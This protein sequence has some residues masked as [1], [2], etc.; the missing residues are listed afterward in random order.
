M[1]NDMGVNLEAVRFNEF[2]NAPHLRSLKRDRNGDAVLTLKGGTKYKV[3]VVDGDRRLSLQNIKEIVEKINQILIEKQILDPNQEAPANNQQLNGLRIN[4]HGVTWNGNV[5]EHTNTDN[6]RGNTKQLY[7]DL[8][9]KAVALN[10]PNNPVQPNQPNQP[11]PPVNPQQP[12]NPNVP[13]QQAPA[14]PAPGAPGAQPLELG[15][16]PAIN[17][18][19]EAGVREITVQADAACRA[20][21]M[22][23]N[24]AGNLQYVAQDRRTLIN[25]EDYA[26][27]LTGGLVVQNIMGALHAI[28]E[29]QRDAVQAAVTARCEDFA[30]N[31]I[32]EGLNNVVDAKI[33]EKRAP[34]TA[35]NK[36]ERD[37]L[38]MTAATEVQQAFSQT[39]LRVGNAGLREKV[40]I[41]ITPEYTL[42]CAN[43]RLR[44]IEAAEAQRRNQP[45]MF[46][47]AAGG[48]GGGVAKAASGLGHLGWGALRRLTGLND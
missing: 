44:L 17:G 1:N 25:W 10:P 21:R 38:V 30:L 9:A 16:I 48:L 19:E 5:F 20:A 28:P 29:N 2:A 18:V 45:G 12:Q 47:R 4:S 40:R 41:A 11:N 34:R 42:A 26:T 27:E 23:T 7:K 46:S 22:K 6:G 33:G 3:S 43:E 35:L 39:M 37:T 15:P 32:R 8:K 13:P 31:V 24:A 14:R 36:A